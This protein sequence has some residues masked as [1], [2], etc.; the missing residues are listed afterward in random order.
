MLAL[1][2]ALLLAQADE[3]P[4][5]RELALAERQDPKQEPFPPMEPP[6][7]KRSSDRFIDLDWLEITPA[8]GFSVYSSKYLSDPSMALSITVR[9]PMPWLSP[10]GD[11]GGE[12]FGLFAEASFMTIDRDMS[13]SVDHRKGLA[14]FFA[15]GPDFSILRD[16]TWILMGR[17]G[18]LY[19]YYG[20][21][22]DLSSGFGGMAGLSAGLQLSGKTGLIYSPEVLFGKSGS[23]VFLNTFGV[24]IQF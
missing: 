16:S 8:I 22:A 18:L 17:A 15:A 2:A 7:A 14:S 13:P 10:R 12:Y 11:P 23:V 6:P 24:T 19:A 9:A 5:P 1:I 4:L 21:I 3:T 20:S